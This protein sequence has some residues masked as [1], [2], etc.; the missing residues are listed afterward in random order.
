M[1]V[2]GDRAVAAHTEGY[3]CAQAVVAAVCEEFGID[4]VTAFQFSG[5]FGGGIARSGE[6]CGAVSGALM[7]I[8]MKY[9]KTSPVDDVSKGKCYDVAAEFL[10]KF[11]DAHHGCTKCRELLNGDR[12]NPEEEALMQQ[13]G[14]LSWCNDF[15]R[16]A[17]DTAYELLAE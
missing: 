10:R 12:F 17:A 1:S 9:A 8:G 3:N 14:R 11:Q 5:A 15:I 13:D 6:T 16:Y 2:F 4:R 7:L